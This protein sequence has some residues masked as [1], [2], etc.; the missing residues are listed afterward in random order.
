[1]S[2]RPR[3]RQLLGHHTCKHTLIHMQH[4]YV[5][6]YQQYLSIAKGPPLIL[7]VMGFLVLCRT[8]QNATL[9]SREYYHCATWTQNCIITHNRHNNAQRTRGIYKVQRLMTDVDFQNRASLSQVRS[10][11]TECRKYNWQCVEVGVT[12]SPSPSVVSY[13]Y[14]RERRMECVDGSSDGRDDRDCVKLLRSTLLVFPVAPNGG[15]GRNRY[16]WIC[17]STMVCKLYCRYNHLKQ[18][19]VQGV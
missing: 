17:N 2:F 10:N 3:L 1:M 19:L 5:H 18:R 12:G 8:D 9:R 14:Q 6:T 16:K 13:P 4:S 7:L 15:L 11:V